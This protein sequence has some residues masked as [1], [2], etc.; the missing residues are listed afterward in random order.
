MS[1]AHIGATAPQPATTK[2]HYSGWQKGESGT[3]DRFR[4]PLV[5]G[6]L[7]LGDVVG[8]L[9]ALSISEAL[10][11]T[12]G[13][14]PPSSTHIPILFLILALFSV[15]LYAASGPSPYERFRLRALATATFAAIDL[16]INL[17][18]G[19]P[20]YLAV[21]AACNAIC[22]V[23]I[24]HYIEAL[25][26]ALLI[27]FDMWGA[28]TAVI[29]CGDD[30]RRLAQLL[31]RQQDLGLSLIGFIETSEASDSQKAQLPGP[32][33][34]TMADPASIRSHVE[35]VI[36]SSAENLAAFTSNA[37]E[38]MPSWQLLLVEDAQDIQSLWL[39][40]RMFRGAIG[41]EIRRDLCLTHNW[42]IKRSI[43]IVL[44]VA[45]ALLAWPIVALL[46]LAIKLVDRG[47]AFYV[48][49]RIGRNG[50]ILRMF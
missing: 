38:R 3:L 46:A 35:V 9:V 12:I 50:M 21:A 4:K 16:L 29:G 33:I 19:R 48:Q 25:V 5:A 39:H 31:M 26:R 37:Q 28:R 13:L 14:L 11:K 40:T 49:D 34:G 2:G 47:P 36:F 44:A 18:V 45:L 15:N 24:G 1:M 6:A 23:G 7:I 30:S 17:P 32:V 41:I 43:D 27:Y 8:A 22:L 20:S 42:L 10:T